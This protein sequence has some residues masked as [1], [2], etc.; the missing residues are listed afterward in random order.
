M[1]DFTEKFVKQDIKTAKVG[2]NF[3]AG[4]DAILA[5]FPGLD[6]TL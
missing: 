2:A 5:R 4:R 3:V 1:V 6:V